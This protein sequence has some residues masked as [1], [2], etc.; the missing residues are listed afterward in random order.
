MSTYLLTECGNHV[1]TLTLNR[2]EKRNALNGEFVHAL[3]EEVTKLSKD[4]TLRALRICA[5]G[6]D[7]CAGGDLAWMQQIANGSEDEN[8]KDAQMLADLLYALYYFPVPTI[9]V[10]HGKSLGGGM[11]LLAVC[12]MVVASQDAIFG[13]P[14][15]KRGLAPSVISPFIFSCLNERLI[16]YYFLTGELFSASDAK[17]IGFIHAVADQETIKKISDDWIETILKNKPQATREIKKLIFAV[18]HEKITASL[19]QKTAEHLAALRMTEEAQA[20]FKDFIT[21]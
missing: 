20:G 10:A 6:K 9:A 17:V 11:G 7:F 18:N 5:A 4:H 14:E 15:V 8:Y 12:D 13:F 3:L 1:V 2:P 19:S 16:K 21:K